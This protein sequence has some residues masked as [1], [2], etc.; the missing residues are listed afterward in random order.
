MVITH[1]SQVFSVEELETRS[2]KEIIL[3]FENI[4]PEKN[5]RFVFEMT[6]TEMFAVQL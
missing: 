3:Y 2:L 1:I 6:A 4:F 5:L